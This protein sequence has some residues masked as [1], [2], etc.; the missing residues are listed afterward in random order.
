MEA[1]R[2]RGTA[3]RR[4]D[5]P[6]RPRLDQRAEKATND[7]GWAELLSSGRADGRERAQQGAVKLARRFEQ[8]QR[9]PT[10]DF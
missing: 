3:G 5:T 9:T 10:H 4:E 1:A 8:A 2:L 6:M 7:G